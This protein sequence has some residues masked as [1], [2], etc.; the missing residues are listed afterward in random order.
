[1]KSPKYRTRN[2]AVLALAGLVVALVLQSHDRN[3][4]GSKDEH[5][6]PNQRTLGNVADLKLPLNF[7][8]N[9]GQTD[10]QVKFLA[11][12]N[13]Y[14]LFLTATEAVLR[15]RTAD[16]GLRIAEPTLNQ[17]AIRNPANEAGQRQPRFA[18]R[19]VG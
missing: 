3:L 19:R 7:E 9:H 16:R 17:S 6:A 4:P 12:G 14:N 13:G 1:M 18:D 8:A 2:L 15:L 5:P 10:S 11:R